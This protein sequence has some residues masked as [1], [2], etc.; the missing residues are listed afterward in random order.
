MFKI[1]F[2]TALQAPECK[3]TAII[4]AAT[5]ILNYYLKKISQFQEMN[6]QQC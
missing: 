6:W 3:A 1:S 5:K 4:S 2:T